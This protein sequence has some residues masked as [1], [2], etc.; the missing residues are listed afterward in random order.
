V[1]EGVGVFQGTKKVRRGGTW[2]TLALRGK[3]KRSPAYTSKEKKITGRSFWEKKERR[4]KWGTTRTTTRG[5]VGQEESGRL[6]MHRQGEEKGGKGND[7]GRG[8]CRGD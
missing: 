6:A 5:T 4:E 7:R 2:L 1:A 8:K 3:G